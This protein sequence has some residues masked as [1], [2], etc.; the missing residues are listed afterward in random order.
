MGDRLAIAPDIH[1][2]HCWY[3]ER[4][5][6]NLC[7]NIRLLGITPGYPGGF[8]ERMVLTGEVLANGIVHPVPAGLSDEFAAMAEPCS[9]VLA[10]HAKAQT[11][12]DDR[13]GH[14]RLRPHRLPA[15]G[16]G[17]G[18]RGRR[19]HHRRQRRSAWQC[20]SA[21]NRT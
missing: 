3:C 10:A 9:S 16:G 6:Y 11:G 5:Q 8:A 14:H 18:A 13:V 15:R 4:G 12:I 7:D 1:C 2:G 20:R 19:L 21:L 17:K